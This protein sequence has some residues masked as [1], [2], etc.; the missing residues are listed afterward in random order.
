[1][2][3][4]IKSLSKEDQPTSRAEQMA[5]ATAIYQ[6]TKE[7]NISLKP[8]QFNTPNINEPKFINYAVYHC[9]KY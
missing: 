5:K 6:S 1:M 7:K 8:E 2:K 3:S 4:I 9:F